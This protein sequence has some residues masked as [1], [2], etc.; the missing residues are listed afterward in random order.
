MESLLIYTLY[1]NY[2]NG[3]QIATTVIDGQFNAYLME[4]LAPYQLVGISI[5][6]TTVG[7]EGPQSNYTFN[8]TQQSGTSCNMK[9]KLAC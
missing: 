9:V 8:R 3:S 2:T 7:G 1:I 6:A 4:G 5:S